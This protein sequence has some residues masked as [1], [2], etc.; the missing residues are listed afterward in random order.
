MLVVKQR[1]VLGDCAEE[2][3]PL[4]RVMKRVHGRR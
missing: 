4:R 2:V 1:G 3:A